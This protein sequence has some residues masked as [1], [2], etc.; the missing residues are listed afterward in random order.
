MSLESKVIGLLC[1]CN[2]N[3]V[4]QEEKGSR[5]YWCSYM[6]D[7]VEKL[8]MTPSTFDTCLLFNDNMT[9]IVGLQT[10]D[11]LIA[12]TTEFMEME[13]RELHAAGLVA[14]PCERL[15]PEQPLDFNGFVI[16][17]GD[18][19]RIN[20]L[21]QAK[22][23]QLLSKTFTKEQYIAQRARG[24]YI[25]TVSQPQ[26]AFALS[27]AA[28]ITEPT[29][30]NAQYLNRCLSWQ[31]GKVVLDYAKRT[32]PNFPCVLAHPVIKPRGLA[33]GGNIAMGFLEWNGKTSWHGLFAT[34][35]LLPILKD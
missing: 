4:G 35:R 23:I 16:T 27:Y 28:Q 17:L 31:M 1:Y 29:Y 26:A 12:D 7:H 14:R 6:G 21:K 15:T 24:A 33:P 9:A 19:M 30:E 8:G 25:A 10:D 5:L 34:V 20:Q 32:T 11:S 18:N 2:S 22:K 3:Q 13:S